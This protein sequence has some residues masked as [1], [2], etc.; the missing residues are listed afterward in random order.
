MHLF[1]LDSLHTYVLI[2]FLAYV[3][4]SLTFLCYNKENL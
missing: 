4:I 2:C 1:P 3:L